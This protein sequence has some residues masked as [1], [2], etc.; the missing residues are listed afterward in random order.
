MPESSKTMISPVEDSNG[1]D[2]WLE[3]C[4]KFS[5][6]GRTKSHVQPRRGSA[7]RTAPTV[8]DKHNLLC[9]PRRTNYPITCLGQNHAAVLNYWGYNGLSMRGEAEIRQEGPS[10]LNV[11][12]HTPALLSVQKERFGSR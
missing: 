6:Y 9:F 3:V 10:Q 1:C 12:F 11:T 5:G 4:A 8:S 7:P 2:L